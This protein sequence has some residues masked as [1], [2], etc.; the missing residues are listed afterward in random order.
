MLRRILLILGGVMLLIAAAL[1]VGHDVTGCWF[2]V[3]FYGLLLVISILCERSQ[4]RPKVNPNLPGWRATEERFVD[5]T[6]GRLMEVR[7][8]ENT[9]ERAYV[10]VDE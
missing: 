7:Y 5:P 10:A 9:G 6:T 1:Y 2:T 4:Y 3:G 8:N